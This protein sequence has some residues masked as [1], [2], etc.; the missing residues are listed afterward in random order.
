[1]N[2]KLLSALLALLTVAS[3]SLTACSDSTDGGTTN[4]TTAADGAETTTEAVVSEYTKPS[5]NYEGAEFTIASYDYEDQPGYW[6]ASLYC[7]AYAETQ[8]GDVINDSVYERNR[9]VEEELGVSIKLFP[10]STLGSGVN[11]LAKFV[12]AADPVCDIALMNGSGLKTMFGVKGEYLTDIR[13]IEG[14]DLTHSWWDQKSVEEFDILGRLYAVTG[15]ISL[16]SKYAPI[17][18]FFNK[19]M[20][21]DYNLGDMYQMVRDGKWTL[22]QLAKFCADV[23]S[24]LDGDGTM[25]QTDAYGMCHQLSLL[26]DMLLSCDIR[27]TTK[28][29]E[30]ISRLSV[31]NER[32]IEAVE[33]IVPLLNNDQITVSTSKFTGYN[34]TFM[35]LHLVMFKENRVL[36]NQNQ[37]L[38]TMNM[39]DMETDFGIIPAP[40]LNEAQ[41]E[42]V[43]MHS[44]WWST[45]LIVPITNTNLKMTGEVCEAMGYYGQQIVA[46]AYMDVTVLNKTLRDTESEEMINLVLDNIQYDLGRFFDWGG[47]S[48]VISGLSTKNTTNFASAWA[49]NEEKIQAA[50]DATFEGWIE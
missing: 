33:K 4:D 32:T 21:E 25:T 28:D 9:T 24:D 6:K 14:L 27:L 20:V 16:W 41:N 11:E 37:L 31:N 43:A 50:I 30:G 1:M 3:I 40:K 7:E 44:P 17:V 23:S 10:M 49:A 13:E 8:D 35:D 18:Y 39:R 36:F 12:L 42:Y 47:I 5:S 19:Q 38:I 29:D 46:P 26:T 2:K 48:G 45:Y 15:D 34:N 22:D